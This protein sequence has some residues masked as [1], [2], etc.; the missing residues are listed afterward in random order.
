MPIVIEVYAALH[1][2]LLLASRDGSGDK[3][4]LTIKCLPPLGSMI[5]IVLY[6]Q[7]MKRCNDYNMMTLTAYDILT[8]HDIKPSPQRLA[9]MDYLMHSCTHPTI[10]EMHTSL[11]RQMPTLSKTTIYNTLRTFVEHGAA[12]M[13]T[14]NEKTTCY[15]A[16]TE[17]HAHFICERCNKVIDLYHGTEDIFPKCETMHGHLIKSMQVYYKGI[18]KDCKTKLT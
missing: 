2:L 12:Q 18:C 14:I 8:G 16:D 7:Q 4:Y 1:A 3:H 10:D 6:L 15:D 11:V 13:L 5:I 17:P 9:I